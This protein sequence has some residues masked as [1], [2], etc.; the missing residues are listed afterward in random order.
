[1][2]AWLFFLCAG[3]FDS[4]S[5]LGQLP[6]E[7]CIDFDI[8]PEACCVKPIVVAFNNTFAAHSINQCSENVKH[9][10]FFYVTVLYF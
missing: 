3:C 7:H 6:L 8:S 10:M 1:M 2:V 4:V 9:L 5:L